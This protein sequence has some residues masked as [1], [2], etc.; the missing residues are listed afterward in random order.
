MPILAGIVSGQTT[1]FGRRP[2]MP[3][4]LRRATNCPPPQPGFTSWKA[5]TMMGAVW[6]AAVGHG[7]PRRMPLC[8]EYGRAGPL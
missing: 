5:M 8:V 1:R 2:A 6:S 4:R 3:F 7:G